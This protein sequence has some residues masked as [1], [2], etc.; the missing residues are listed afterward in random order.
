MRAERPGIG[1][2]TQRLGRIRMGFHE[3][4]GDARSHGR[5]RQH[6]DVFALT[7]GARALPAR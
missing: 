2:V 6:R 4:A 3:Q 1:P 5:A 7:A